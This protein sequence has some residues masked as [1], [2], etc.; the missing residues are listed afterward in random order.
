M[1]LCACLSDLQRWGCVSVSF[2]EAEAKGLFSFIAGT[3]EGLPWRETLTASCSKYHGIDILSS[4][5][6]TL[7]IFGGVGAGLMGVMQPSFSTL[8]PRPTQY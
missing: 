4:E 1:Y 3:G 5:F 2:L 6:I 7:V 8:P